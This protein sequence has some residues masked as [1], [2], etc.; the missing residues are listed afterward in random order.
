VPLFYPP[1]LYVPPKS[2]GVERVS[3]RDLEAL[4]SA[5]TSDELDESGLLE[6]TAPLFGSRTPT[7]DLAAVCVYRP[8]STDVAHMSALTGRAHRRNGY[9]SAAA[10]AAIRHAIDAEL[11]RQEHVRL[12]GLLA[13]YTGDRAVAEDLAQEVLLRLHQHWPRVRL[14]GSPH[15]WLSSVGMNLARS[16]WRRRYAEQRAYRRLGATR[17]NASGPPDLPTGVCSTPPPA[18]GSRSPP[19]RFRRPR[20]GGAFVTSAQLVDD[21][22]AVVTGSADGG[23]HAAV[24]DVVED[25]W[26]D[27]PEQ[28]EI[29]LAYDAMAWDGETLA[30]VRTRPGEMGHIGE[31][32]LDWSVD[33]PI[34][35][36]W[37]F[38]D[39]SWTTGTPPPFGLRDY[40]GAAFD[41]FRLALWGGMTAAQR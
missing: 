35:L 41:G 6:V 15:A 5:V 39:D 21:R 34:T 11:C 20:S 18:G 8:L 14:M 9:T 33:T 1:Q 36:R 2:T 10:I 4:L 28:A 3:R 13:L 16:W 31:G 25:R 23:L 17:S 38:G 22:L 37:R 24:Y 26:I 40:V 7:G 19:L 32:Q 12:V 30:L 27:A 29:P